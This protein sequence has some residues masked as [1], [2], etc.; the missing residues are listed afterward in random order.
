L[1]PEDDEPTE[2]EIEEILREGRENPL[3]LDDAKRLL[4]K[5]GEHLGI[6][7]EEADR[8]AEERERL[9]RGHDQ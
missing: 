1:R 8:I 6:S 2:A 7:P 3:P 5:V 4:R 9:D